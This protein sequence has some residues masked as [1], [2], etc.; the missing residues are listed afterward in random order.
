MHRLMKSYVMFGIIILATRGSWARARNVDLVTLPRRDTVQLTIYNSEDLT[1]AKETRT[2]ALKKGINRLQFSWAGTLIDPTSVDFR[3]L[4]HADQIEVADTVFP[5][6]KPQHLVWNIESGI[7]GQVPVEVT[8]FT[9]GLTWQMDYVGYCDSREETLD[10]RGFVR[11]FNQSGEEYENAEIRLIVGNINLVEKIAELARRA[12]MPQPP[13]SEV[14]SDLKHRAMRESLSRAAVAADEAAAEPA[15]A[16]KAI[17]KEGLSEYFMFS[18]EGTET[19]PSG[20]SKKMRAVRGGNVPFDIVYRHRA[21]QYGPRPQ[22]FFVWRNDK[23][24]EL[25]GSPLPN[26]V[27]RLFRENGREGLSFLGQQTLN[28]VPIQAPIEVNLGPDDLIVI[29]QTQQD[30]ARMNFDFDQKNRHVTGWDERQRWI[31]SVRNYRDKPIAFELRLQFSGDVD[32]QSEQPANAFDFRT[33]E[34]KFDVAPLDD[35]KFEYMTTVHH[36]TNARQ[37]R[38]KLMLG[39]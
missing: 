31:A 22:R 17:V 21:Y 25:G 13:K 28:Y 29:T 4:A 34:S 23:E 3:P 37:D 27:V 5:G 30:V 33:I 9:S 11:V 6:E 32:F 36:G 7:E 20:W 35:T 18:V 12:G 15:L 26:G 39:R 8:Y 2:I 1:L 14:L 10:F 38:V 19:I 16:R 24:H